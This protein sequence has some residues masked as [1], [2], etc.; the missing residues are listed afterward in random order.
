MVTNKVRDRTISADEEML[1]LTALRALGLVAAR[2]EP[3]TE[4]IRKGLSADWWYF[5]TNYLSA[6]PHLSRRGARFDIIAVTP[7]SFP[8]HHRDAWQADF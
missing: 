8:V 7:Y 4:I 6:R 1:K 5:R 2:Y 3:V